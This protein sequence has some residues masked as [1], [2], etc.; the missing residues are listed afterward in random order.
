M[1]T[2]FT[3]DQGVI[4]ENVTETFFCGRIFCKHSVT[5]QLLA[6]DLLIQYSGVMILVEIFS[7]HYSG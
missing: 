2:T 5:G 6:T 7:R 3:Q 4:F 1:K